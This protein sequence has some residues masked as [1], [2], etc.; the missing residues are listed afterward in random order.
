MVAIKGEEIKKAVLRIL[1]DIKENPE[2]KL[3]KLY[4]VASIFLA[5]GEVVDMPSLK[6]MADY[7]VSAPSRFNQLLSYKYQVMGS[8]LEEKFGKDIDSMLKQFFDA[9]EKCANL[10][11]KES[12]DELEILKLLGQL[13]DMYSKMPSLRE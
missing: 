1:K 9:I 12:I 8:P 4:K 2:F 3:N 5:I 6:M 7:V 13:E 10:I 11:A